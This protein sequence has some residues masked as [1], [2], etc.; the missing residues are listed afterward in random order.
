MTDTIRDYCLEPRDLDTLKRLAPDSAL[1][2]AT[3][4]YRAA[5]SHEAI[6]PGYRENRRFK[7]RN[8]FQCCAAVN[9]DKSSLNAEFDHGC[10]ATHIAYVN[11]IG[12]RA[13]D[14]LRFS[15]LMDKYWFLEGG[16]PF[17]EMILE[18]ADGPEALKQ[19]AVPCGL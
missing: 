12:S 4:E 6:V 15:R 5:L 17:S 9:W 8:R 3:F 1:F 14:I 18:L 11:G 10:T 13:K 16:L 2:H 19:T 7:L